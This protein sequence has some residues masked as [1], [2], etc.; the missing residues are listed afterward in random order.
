MDNFANKLN[1]IDQSLT[2]VRQ[3]LGIEDQPIEQID[4]TLISKQEQYETELELKNQT[5]EELASQ[6]NYVV[7]TI[8]EMEALENVVS[9]AMCIVITLNE[10]GG[11]SDFLGTYVY[12]ASRGWFKAPIGMTLSAN[13]VLKNIEYNSDDGIVVGNLGNNIATTTGTSYAIQL[14]KAAGNNLWD[15]EGEHTAQE[16]FEAINPGNGL[17]PLYKIINWTNY[18]DFSNFMILKSQITSLDLSWTRPITV[19]VAS[20]FCKGCAGLTTV[21]IPTME[22]SAATSYDAF[23]M[24]CSN[25]TKLDISGTAFNTEATTADMLLNVPA[26]C[27]IIVKDEAAKQFLLSVRNDLTNIIIK[28]GE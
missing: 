22:L 19:Q 24:D 28:G 27:E 8:E 17:S 21:L 5:I 6:A 10:D 18:T 23:L 25:L 12:E 16:I 20:G 3:I 14:L 1:T 11:Y 9:G 26:N 15:I 2:E 7:S 13:A 4:L